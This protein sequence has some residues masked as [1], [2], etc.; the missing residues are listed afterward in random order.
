MSDR[1]AD[2]DATLAATLQAAYDLAPP[3]VIQPLPD[4]GG[5]NNAVRAVRTGAGEFVWKRY[6]AH[7]DPAA[8][9]RE[10]R[11]LGR[12]SEARLSFAVPVPLPARDGATLCSLPDGAGWGVLAP[13]LP[14]GPLDRHDPQAVAALGAALGELH[15]A[16]AQLRIA[17][18]LPG[19]EYGALHRIH[20]ALS[21]PFALTPADL[22]LPASSPYTEAL[23]WFRH[24]LAE[25]TAFIAGPSFAGSCS[26]G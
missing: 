2:G 12:L 13:R 21:D 25:L 6:A 18:T 22:G 14:G 11:L 23:A 19:K 16:L 5:I 20:P 8:I 24:F 9:A 26:P 4:A 1:I 3:V 17:P 7:G 15:R 10:H